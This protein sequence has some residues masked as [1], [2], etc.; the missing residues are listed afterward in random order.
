MMKIALLVIGA[1]YLAICA[2]WGSARI[3]M[4]IIGVDAAAIIASVT[5]AATLMVVDAAGPKAKQ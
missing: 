1:F 2:A 4:P 3:L 5:F